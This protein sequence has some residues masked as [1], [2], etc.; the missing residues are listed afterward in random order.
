MIVKP[1][2]H[3]RDRALNYVRDVGSTTE[4]NVDSIAWELCSYRR[5][6]IDLIRREIE[7]VPDIERDGYDIFTVSSILDELDE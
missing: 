3:E 5:W 4:V 7:L 1:S 2:K 6:M